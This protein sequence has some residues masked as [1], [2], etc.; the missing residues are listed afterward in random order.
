MEH[1]PQIAVRLPKMRIKLNG[2]AVGRRRRLATTQIVQRDSEVI[3]DVGVSAV[4]D[5]RLVEDMNRGLVLASRIQTESE[6]PICFRILRI[7]TQRC[8]R[9]RNGIVCIV[10]TIENIGQ[11][12]VGLGK[13]GSDPSDSWYGSKASSQSPCCWR[14]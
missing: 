2:L 8:A 7:E 13:T 11:P 6:I 1:D 4:A 14:R 12:A 3:P 9:L 5:Q 10:G